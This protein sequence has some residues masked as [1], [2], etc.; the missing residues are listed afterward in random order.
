MKIEVCKENMDKIIA[1]LKGVNGEAK[2]HTYIAYDSIERMAER[3]ESKLLGLVNKRDAKGA[4]YV[5]RSGGKLPKSYNN[6]R[7]VTKVELTRGS[8]N[9]FITNVACTKAWNDEGKEYLYLTPYQG[10]QAVK[11]FRGKYVA[12]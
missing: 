3:A 7:L 5:S 4:V 10:E 1:A 6:S 9:W 11:K 2:A 8:S 12:I